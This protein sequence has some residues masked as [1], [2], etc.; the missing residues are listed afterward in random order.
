MRIIDVDQH[1][2]E[3]RTTWSDYID[4]SARDDALRIEDDDKGWPYLVWRGHRLTNIEVPIPENSAAIG[5]A[6]VQ[7]TT[8]QRAE[9]SFEELVPTAY[10]DAGARLAAMDEFGIDEAVLFPNYGLLWENMLAEDRAAQRA[11]ARAFNRF[12]AD[13]ISQGPVASTA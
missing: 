12:M 2:F 13:T 9:A 3:S 7:R 8:G 5:R 6:H 4:P 11:N 1:L 10:G